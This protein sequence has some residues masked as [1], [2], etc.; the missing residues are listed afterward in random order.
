MSLPK[1]KRVDSSSIEEIGYDKE[2]QE[3]YIRFLNNGSLYVY[4]NVP[5]IEFTSLKEASSH[6]KYFH[7]NI[8]NNY[9]CEK[10]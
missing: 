7:H 3:L 1:M 4:R 5:E 6:G 8:K 10:L 9:P 2:Q